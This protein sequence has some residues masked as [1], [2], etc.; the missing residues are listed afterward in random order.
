MPRFAQP[1]WLLLLLLVP[2]L[3][4]WWR[5]RQQPA[6]RFPQT[7]LL[8]QVPSLRSRL[9]RWGGLGLR[10]AAI[11]LIVLA[12][13]GPRWPR[14]NPIPTEGIAIVMV[15]DV[16]GSMAE[17][18]FDWQGELIS[19]LQAA[20]RAFHLFVK[21]GEGP[22]GETLPGRGTDLVGLVTFAA[23]P[24]SACPLTLSHSVLLRTLDEQSPRVGA[25]ESET[26]ISDAIA[27]GLHRLQSAGK[28]RK[29]LVLLS[30]GE[31]NVPHPQSGW[32]PRQ[33]AQIAANLGVPIYAID[34]G[35]PPDPKAPGGRRALQAIAEISSG[36]YFEARDTASLLQVCQRIDALERQTI[37]SFQYRRY[38]ELFAWFSLAALTALVLVQALESTVWRRLP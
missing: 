25:G 4:G 30:D 17:M 12:L 8:A 34:A 3:M 2:L 14:G 31:H 28:R 29:V 26:N 1:W 32:T 5:K 7:G 33:A 9:A 35:G 16:S 37:E 27:L 13:A 38:T 21:G 19:R 23:R 15:V 10:T 11:V 36:R 24:E 18:D 6:L 20:Q 22:G